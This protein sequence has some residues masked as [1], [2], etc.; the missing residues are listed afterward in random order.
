VVAWLPAVLLTVT[1]LTTFF[2][3]VGSYLGGYPVY[4]QSPWRATFG[5]VSRNFALEERMP[6]DR[7]WLDKLRSDW[8]IMV[9]YLL[10]L[11]AALAVAWADRGLSTFDPRRLPPL[12]KLWPWRKAV[13]AGL[14]GFAFLLV[15]TEV[16][17]GFG[18]ERAIRAMVRENPELAKLREDAGNS[19]AKLAMVENREEQELAKYNLEET[20]WQRLGLGCN[21]LAALT[22]LLSIGLDRRGSKPPPKILL[23]Y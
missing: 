1:F 18:M 19:E 11:L 14:A 8:E 16:S 17:R 7:G 12:A 3:W 9:P 15:F 21:L 13:V 10:L 2:P 4:S 23:H 6:G 20:T 5:S 22:A